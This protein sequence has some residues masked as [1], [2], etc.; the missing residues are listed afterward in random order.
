MICMRLW[1]LCVYLRCVAYLLA[2]L[3][4]KLTIGKTR[5]NTLSRRRD[6]NE[7]F[8]C[9]RRLRYRPDFIERDMVVP[10]WEV[11]DRQQHSQMTGLMSG[12]STY[13]HTD[14]HMT[15]G[16]GGGMMDDGE[17]VVRRRRDLIGEDISFTNTLFA[18]FAFVLLFFIAAS[19]WGIP[20]PGM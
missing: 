19:P 13:N 8:H 6:D 2:I 11:W 4:M 1:Q 12:H 17:E 16:G 9:S 15:T 10:S 18:V 20:P 14:S 3:E 5:L 7:L